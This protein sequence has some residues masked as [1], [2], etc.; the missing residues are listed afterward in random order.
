MKCRICGNSEILKEYKV[1][2]MMFGIRDEFSYFE[3]GKCGCLQIA[4]IPKDMSKYYPSNYYSYNAPQPIA[5]PNI[6]TFF[7]KIR[8]NYAIFGK[9]ILGKLL[10]TY[11]P[12]NTLKVLSYIP[13][14]GYWTIPVQYDDIE[15][16]NSF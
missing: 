13:V 5:K 14:T 10:Y 11:F 6:N 15:R 9:G 3:C 1:K 16:I 2:E 4:S 8:Y 12:K 7:K